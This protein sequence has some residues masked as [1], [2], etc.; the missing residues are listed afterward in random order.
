[1]VTK[2]RSQAEIHEQAARALYGKAPAAVIKA[3]N[4]LRLDIP[5]D[6]IEADS[7]LDR[8]GALATSIEWKRA[9]TVYARVPVCASR[10]RPPASENGKST[11]LLS[12]DQFATL[13]IHGLRAPRTIRNYW[14]A[15]DAAISDGI[16]RPVSLGDEVDIPT[17]PWDDYYP[18]PQKQSEDEDY[19]D[20]GPKPKP[21]GKAKG[22]GKRETADEPDD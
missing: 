19:P 16:A 12:P 6:H 13:G 9:A 15:W 11:L 21:K 7:M 1:M 3:V 14:R 4:P 10:G 5:A 8:L 2:R 20:D 18:M 22:K 17:E